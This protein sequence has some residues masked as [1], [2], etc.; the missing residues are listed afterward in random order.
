MEAGLDVL[1]GKVKKSV[2]RVEK[3]GVYVSAT[4]SNNDDVDCKGVEVRIG[5]R[6]QIY[7]SV[8][9]LY[10][11][12]IRDDKIYEKGLV[13]ITYVKRDSPFSLPTLPRDAL[14]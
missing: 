14:T 3:P 5:I 8:L 13:C 9:D 11:L 10:E 2:G 1:N 4:A 7:V 6:N 12:P